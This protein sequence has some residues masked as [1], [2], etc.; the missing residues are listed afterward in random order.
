[1]KEI[2]REQAEEIFQIY[3]VLDK[4]IVQTKTELKLCFSL[5]NNDSLH[6][7]YDVKSHHQSFFIDRSSSISVK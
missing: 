4:E 5:S 3:K 1:M 7:I 2:T 6:V